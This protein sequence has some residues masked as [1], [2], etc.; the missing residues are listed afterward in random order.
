MTNSMI[1]T[2]LSNFKYISFNPSLFFESN[3]PIKVIQPL[4]AYNYVDYDELNS[5]HSLC[6]QVIIMK[7][8]ENL[9]EIDL[10]KKIYLKKDQL[11]LC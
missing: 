7:N 2:N 4:T 11:A 5:Y 3:R 9:I 10:T 1:S 8:N 6:K